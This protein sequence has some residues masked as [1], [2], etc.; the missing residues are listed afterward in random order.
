MTFGKAT[1]KLGLFSLATH[2]IYY[3][4]ALA[5]VMPRSTQSPSRFDEWISTEELNLKY[6]LTHQRSSSDSI[7]PPAPTERICPSVRL[8]TFCLPACL[9]SPKR[10]IVVCHR[11]LFHS[12][13]K[14]AER[15]TY[16]RNEF[17]KSFL[18]RLSPTLLHILAHQQ[19]I[20]IVSAAG[21][22]AS[23]N[24]RIYCITFPRHV[25]SSILVG[26]SDQRS[27]FSS[28]STS[29]GMIIW[30]NIYWNFCPDW[31]HHHHHRHQQHLS[32]KFD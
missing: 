5:N 22:G 4:A 29:S 26:T 11:H 10:V 15:N 25:Q 18:L 31:R 17:G 9:F 28:N 23:V 27:S 7:L 3:E 30:G 19:N 2:Q 6:H 12:G 21:A 13:L 14:C 20:Y 16:F 8:S 32:R 1:P 24:H